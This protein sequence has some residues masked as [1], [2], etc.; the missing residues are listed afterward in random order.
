MLALIITVVFIF[1]LAIGVPIS[2]ALGVPTVIYFVWQDIPIQMIVQR[3]FAGI[4]NFTLLAI[5]F[6]MF[7]GR[8]MNE[9]DITRRIVD[10][11]KA[12]TGAVRAGLAMVNIIAS[13]LFAGISGAATADVAS[14][15]AVLIP[16]MKKEGYSSDY[17]VAITAMSSI[18]GPIIPP[19]VVFILYGVLS[20][21]SI[22]GLF[23]AG[24]V[25][26]F[27]LGFI[28]MVIV[29]LEGKK[30]GFPKGEPTSW[31]L[32]GKSLVSSGLAMVL[33]FIIIGGMLGGVFTATEA[34]AVASF[35]ALILA[36]LVYRK[37]KLWNVL[38]E[39]AL[40]TANVMV[41]VGT[42]TIFAWMLTSEEI[43]QKTGTILLSISDN[44]YIILLMINAL[45]LF[46]GTFMDNFPAMIITIP[47]LLPIVKGLGVHPLHF[48]VIMTVNLMIGTVTPPVGMVIYLASA[49]GKTSIEKSAIAMKWLLLASIGI[50]L[51][52]TYIP[53]ISMFIPRLVGFK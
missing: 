15:G 39:T 1:S 29:Y 30:R 32:F 3:I 27:M 49:I 42:S 24:I 11:S 26:G 36:M 34:G 9:G 31:A 45:L 23:M 40:D 19:S 14:I 20:G 13:M 10:F 5:P 18:I 35:Y 7:A 2:L 44:P 16:A 53:A 25:P 46:I 28:Q 17:S 8:I 43:P 52:V 21:T 38:T 41:I 48:G 37:L 50:L 33:P 4:N 12:I 47:V 51:L 22:I 6:F